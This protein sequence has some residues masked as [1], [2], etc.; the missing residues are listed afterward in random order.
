MKRSLFISVVV[1]ALAALACSLPSIGGEEGGGPPPPPPPPS[2]VLF[3][4][5]FNDPN[6]GWEEGDYQG[7]SVGYGNGY[8]FVTSIEAGSMMWGLAFQSFD[9]LVISV[10]A[11]Q[12]SA[13]AND[14]NAY[15]V[16]CRVQSDD[17]GY[18]LRISGDGYYAIH[19]VVDGE[20]QP[21]VDWTTTDVVNLGNATNH[22]R[23]ICDGPNLILFANGQRLAEVQDSLYTS[24]DIALTAT[25]FEDEGTE[26]HF[27]DLVVSKP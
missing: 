19:R 15:G 17:D 1:L 12:V 7:G 13:P 25:T 21:L 20:F 5:N 23:A 9:D 18:I 24:G 16:M 4:D 8:Y 10:D 11:T 22:I 27:D 2:N 14:N 6:S 26:V 3:E